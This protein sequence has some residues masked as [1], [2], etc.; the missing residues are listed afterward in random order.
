M[1]VRRGIFEGPL[2]DTVRAQLTY[3][4]MTCGDIYAISEQFDE[5]EQK[6]ETPRYVWRNGV[7]VRNNGGRERSLATCV[8]V[9]NVMTGLGMKEQDGMYFMQCLLQARLVKPC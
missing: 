2:T 6:E 9:F 4:E 3:F 5:V 1:K 7:A 8:A